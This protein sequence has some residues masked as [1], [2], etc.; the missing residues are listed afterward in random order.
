MELYVNEDKVLTQAWLD[1]EDAKI[2]VPEG[3][4]AIGE[5]AFFNCKYMKEIILPSTLKEIR[6]EAFSL[7]KSLEK[8]NLPE[9]ITDIGVYA[10]RQCESLKEIVL[11][12]SLDCLEDLAF[13]NC[14]SLQKIILPNS[15]NYIGDRNFDG[16]INLKEIEIPSSVLHIGSCAFTSCYNLEKVVLNEGLIAIHSNAFSYTKLKE[17]H[18]PAT[19]QKISNHVFDGCS[20]LEKVIVPDNV[21]SIQQDAF[22]HCTNL[23]EVKLSNSMKYINERLFYNCES[24][25][26]IIIPD[27]VEHIGS[28]AFG[29]CSS[30][31]KIEFNSN[32][33]TIQEDAFDRTPN[34][35]KFI[36]K[37]FHTLH[38][39][40]MRFKTKVL[41]NF[42][43]NEEKK[44]LILTNETELKLEGYRKI[45]WKD[46]DE[47][48]FTP[49]QA[50]VI[51][52]MFS[53]DKFSKLGTLKPFISRIIENDITID[54]YKEIGNNILNN[55]EYT[56]LIKNIM[57]KTINYYIGKDE[58]YD[59]F[60]FGYSLGLF[61]NDSI[62]RQRVCEFLTNAF[63]NEEIK[64]Y[65][66]HGMLE[67]LKFRTFNK[68]WA[69]FLMN[70][71]NLKKLL[72][73]EQDESG[74]IA[75]VC[76][77]FEKIKEFGRT[78]R[79]DQH[80]RKVTIE[81]INK[82]FS[83]EFIGINDDNYD[84]AEVLSKYTNNQESFDEA[85]EI[86]EKFLKLKK[87][88][89][90]DDHLLKE[91]LLSKIEK[92]KEDII[93]DTSSTLTNLNEIANS[94]FSYE[95]LS[96]YD[97]KNFVLGK[98]CSCCAHIEGMG[99]G[100]MKASILH[101]DCQNLVIKDKRGKIIAKSTLYINRKQGYGVFNNVEINN[102][103]RDEKT[104]KLIYIK[105]K[106]AVTN[107]AKRYNEL[108]KDKQLTQINVGMS[109]NDLK[110][111]IIRNDK[112]DNDVLNAIDFSS[113]GGYKGDWQNEQYVIWKK[114]DK[115]R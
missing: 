2:V 39:K 76:N 103:I 29:D 72:E 57:K 70:K 58:Q 61:D 55:K 28:D 26:K 65:A 3:I 79:G 95:F 54:N 45:N 87:E 13:K 23:K 68:E 11:P 82:Y 96:K 75:K 77:N 114:E 108:N 106:E 41:G 112:E 25:E 40:G 37:S 64:T 43:F 27:S 4:V 21:E 78:N 89:T 9:S 113:F 63:N 51:D 74:Y 97:P 36:I 102:N 30:L 19:L 49:S 15:L 1:K 56:R 46:K 99:I 52:I 12:P 81:I 110:E 60:R 115:K 42:Y 7:C 86:R 32:N 50:V 94:E 93:R 17:I 38:Q 71:N 98:Y 100:I 44:E 91:P 84:I 8:I 14:L 83:S 10:F 73:I 107:F 90:I 88:N 33:I 16:C 18:F 59:L 20:N 53:E 101:P 109:L 5:S 31:K 69:E 6:N 35:N 67:S 80:Y 105:Y 85:N 34:L 66:I 22:A 111:E 92:L 104:K 62:Q 24:L 48:S 47:I